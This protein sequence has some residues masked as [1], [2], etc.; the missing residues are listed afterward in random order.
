[1]KL[2]LNSELHSTNKKKTVPITGIASCAMGTG[3]F[4]GVKSGRG[5]TLTPHPLLG[6][7]SRKS[8][9]TPLLPLWV[10]RPVQSLS[11]CTRVHLIT[12]IMIFNFHRVIIISKRVIYAIKDLKAVKFNSENELQQT[13]LRGYCYCNLLNT[14]LFK[15]SK[16]CQ[17]DHLHKVTT[18]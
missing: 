3:S 12:G 10:V 13:E 11:A 7:W 4:P 8:I 1:M 18:C 5:V 15:Y 17:V 9:A 2:Y 14:R 6:S 16:T